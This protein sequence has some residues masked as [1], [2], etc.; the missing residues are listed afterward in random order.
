MDKAA[1]EFG[2][3]FEVV[4]HPY[5]LDYALPKKGL[6]KRSNYERKRINPAEVESRTDAHRRYTIMKPKRRFDM[7]LPN[8]IFAKNMNAFLVELA[9]EASNTDS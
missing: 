7:F 4:W 6:T 2:A 9:F 8:Y 5:F 3:Q 1:V